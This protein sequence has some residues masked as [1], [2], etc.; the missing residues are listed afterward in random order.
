MPRSLALYNFIQ[1]S[2]TLQGDI[3]RDWLLLGCCTTS[4]I[5]HVFKAPGGKTSPFLTDVFPNT[6]LYFVVEQQFCLKFSLG[7]L[8]VW[9]AAASWPSS[10]STIALGGGGEG[11]PP[12]PSRPKNQ[13][14][15]NNLPP[16][17][18]TAS[19]SHEGTTP[20]YIVLVLYKKQPNSL[21]PIIYFL[22]SYYFL[23]SIVLSGLVLTSHF[24]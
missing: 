12:F 18:P 19:F 6:H 15:C 8:A 21:F 5:I 24:V 7:S 11:G 17:P 14:P 3:L 16:P 1:I 23:M 10:T 20:R 2:P 4:Q 22:I 13:P 9:E